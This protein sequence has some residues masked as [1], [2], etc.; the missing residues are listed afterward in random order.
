M[1]IT[2]EQKNNKTSQDE[3][4]Q[5]L[6]KE[7]IKQKTSIPLTINIHG[8]IYTYD[9]GRRCIDGQIYTYKCR[10]QDTIRGLDHNS[11]K[12]DIKTLIIRQEDL[13]R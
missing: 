7:M 9:G 6:I 1:S 5:I 13:K 4:K 11:V 8:N 10:I 3:L 12:Y 2:I